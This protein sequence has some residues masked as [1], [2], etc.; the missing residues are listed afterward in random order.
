MADYLKVTQV[1][2]VIRR[3]TYQRQSLLG[4]GL[5]RRGRTSYVI[6]TPSNRGLVNTVGHLVTCEEVTAADR[7]AAL[8]TTR[9]RSYEIVENDDA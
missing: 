8:A 6:D 1:R 9:R 2:S 7:D 3:P 5:K 4:L